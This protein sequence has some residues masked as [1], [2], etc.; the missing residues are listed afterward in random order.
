MRVSA[1]RLSLLAWFAVEDFSG[2]LFGFFGGVGVVKVGFVTSCLL[3]WRHFL[4]YLSTVGIRCVTEELMRSV[5]VGLKLQYW[6]FIHVA[7]GFW[8][9]ISS[10][11]LRSD[12][13]S[14]LPSPRMTEMII[15]TIKSIFVSLSNHCLP[16]RKYISYF[17]WHGDANLPHS[18]SHW[19]NSRQT[20]KSW[21]H[22]RVR[23]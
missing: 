7:L 2:M 8:C 22:R 18:T 15:M 21:T 5:V 3:T 11:D 17:S 23:V 4:K 6:A 19:R 13:S 10:L 14:W 9:V 16:L 12:I 1:F 20:D